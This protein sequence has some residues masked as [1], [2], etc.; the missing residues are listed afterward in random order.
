MKSLGKLFWAI[1]VFGIILLLVEAVLFKDIKNSIGSI[2][3]L[4]IFI[5]T[6]LSAVYVSLYIGW[7]DGQLEILAP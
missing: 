5:L 7:K 3:A 6:M 2:P 4:M 1:L